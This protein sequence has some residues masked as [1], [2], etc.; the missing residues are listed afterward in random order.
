MYW[1][2]DQLARDYFLVTVAADAMQDV[3]DTFPQSVEGMLPVIAA[4]V[5]AMSGVPIETAR[6]IV[7]ARASQATEAL[8]SEI[9]RGVFRPSGGYG[10]VAPAGGHCKAGRRRRSD[11][12]MPLAYGHVRLATLT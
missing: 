11:F 1:P 6:A 9:D 7:K 4:Q 12:R 8:T 5:A 2:D 10:R 3:Q